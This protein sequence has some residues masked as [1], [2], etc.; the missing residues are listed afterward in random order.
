MGY[1]LEG[2]KTPDGNV[3]YR[4]VFHEDGKTTI[5]AARESRG[6]IL[7]REGKP[8]FMLCKNSVVGPN[9]I[10]N[11]DYSVTHSIEDAERA[12]HQDLVTLA[13]SY[14]WIMID[15]SRFGRG[16]RK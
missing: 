9:D 15:R 5:V 13:H 7:D 12:A 1:D 11:R 6:P 10:A 14:N 16:K 3:R 8:H 4:L 2:W